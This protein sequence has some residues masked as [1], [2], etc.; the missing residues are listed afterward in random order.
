M[1]YTARAEQKPREVWNSRKK[2]TDKTQTC[3]LQ[4]DWLGWFEVNGTL[5]WSSRCVQEMKTF[6]AVFCCFFEPV[7]RRKTPSYRPSIAC[8]S[9]FL[10]FSL[11]LLSTL[12]LVC[13]LSSSADLLTRLPSP[14][15]PTLH[16]LVIPLLSRSCLAHSPAGRC[17]SDRIQLR[18]RGHGWLR[19]GSTDVF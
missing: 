15:H 14:P 17:N 1:S 19:Y 16:F 11:T 3:S 7:F 18:A 6:T 10:I 8:R 2:G 9:S 5:A 13:H 4:N 12:C